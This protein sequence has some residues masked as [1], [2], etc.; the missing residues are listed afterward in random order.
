MTW[1]HDL[2][3]KAT[4]TMMVVRNLWI[5][6]RQI[7][8][9]TTALWAISTTNWNFPH[10]SPCETGGSKAREIS[11]SCRNL[12]TRQLFLYSFI[13][14]YFCVNPR[15]AL[16]SF[17]D[18][19]KTLSAPSLD[20]IENICLGAPITAYADFCLINIFY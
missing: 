6:K 9:R 18:V 2:D 16:L 12:R 19:R 4:L 5:F 8:I 7:K 20:S 1:W 15:V 3:D 13:S 17:K 14:S 11:I 10:F